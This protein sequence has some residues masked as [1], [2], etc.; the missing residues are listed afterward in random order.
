M[1][2]YPWLAALYVEEDCRGNGYGKMLIEHAVKD[3]GLLGFKNLYLCTD[4]IGFYE[5]FGFDF[6]GYCYHPWGEKTQIYHLELT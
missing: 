4:H 3:A 6:I 2:L 1:D 5:R